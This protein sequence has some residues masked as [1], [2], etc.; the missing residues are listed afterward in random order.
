MEPP[1]SLYRTLV[2]AFG[3]LPLWQK[4]AAVMTSIIFSPAIVVVAALVLFAV[5]PFLLLG[6]FEGVRGTSLGKDVAKLVSDQ[7]ER[8][9]RYYAE[10]R[11]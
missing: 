7:K 1:E 3:E 5:F 8:T 6:K 2:G 10:R 4:A 9:K 11:G